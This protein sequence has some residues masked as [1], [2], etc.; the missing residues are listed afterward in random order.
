MILL[1]MTG[2]LFLINTYKKR[3]RKGDSSIYYLWAEKAPKEPFPNVFSSTGGF[4][5]S[6]HSKP[7]TVF[8]DTF[9][10]Q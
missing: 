6:Y 10:R 5:S 1:H 7:K 2:Y 3:T 8:K 4:Y 9:L